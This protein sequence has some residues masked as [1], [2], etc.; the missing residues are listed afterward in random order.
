VKEPRY[1]AEYLR[2]RDGGGRAWFSRNEPLFTYL[3]DVVL[4][5]LNPRMYDRYK[6]VQRSLP[7]GLEPLC[8]AWLGCAINEGQ[9][10]DGTP[11]IDTNDYAFGYN[12]VTAWG[13]FASSRLLLWQVSQSIE[14]QPGDAVLFLGRLFTHNATCITGGARNVVDAFTHLS[15]LTWHDKRQRELML[16]PPPPSTLVRRVPEPEADGDEDDGEDALRA[17]EREATAQLDEMV[18]LLEGRL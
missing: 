2:D 10:T 15:V 11:H 7:E 3:S 5:N 12:A 8:G 1:S 18:S 14:L 4:R 9:T 16:R 13:D 6:S 17:I